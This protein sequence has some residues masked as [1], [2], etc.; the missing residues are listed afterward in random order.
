MIKELSDYFREYSYG[1][2]KPRLLQIYRRMW[3]GGFR[4]GEYGRYLRNVARFEEKRLFSILKDVGLWKS[5]QRWL[6][7]QFNQWWNFSKIRNSL[8]DVINLSDTRTEDGRVL[9]IIAVD[10]K[11]KIPGFGKRAGSVILTVMY[12]DSYGIIDCKV[13]RA[14]NDKW[15]L[16]YDLDPLCRFKK[17][18]RNCYEVGCKYIQGTVS[19]IDFSLEDC[20]QYFEVIR[21]IG[22]IE[23]MNPRQVDM[24]L[25]EYDEQHSRCPRKNE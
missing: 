1:E 6:D 20:N 25:W 3:E 5:G 15:A 24:A 19:S 22:M 9:G 12:P 4:L 13:W 10:R 11:T 18:C 16:H 17:E 23:N 7:K 21:Q 14:L 8:N 2:K